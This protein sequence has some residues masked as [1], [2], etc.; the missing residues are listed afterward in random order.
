MRRAPAWMAAIGVL[1]GGWTAPSAASAASV[2]VTLAAG[3]PGN[4]TPTS[5]SEFFFDS[6]HAPPEVAVNQLTGGISATATTGGGF[7]AFGNVGTPVLLN[8]ADGS[9]YIAGGSPPASASSAGAA[10]GTPATAAPVAGGAVPS[11]AALLGIN[12][13]EPSNGSRSLTAT[14]TDSSGTSLGSGTVAVPMGGWWVLGLSPDAVPPTPVTIPAPPPNTG[15]APD[16]GPIS[17]PG[18]ISDPGPV[19]GGGSNSPPTSPGGG[20]VT[21]PEPTPLALAVMG[22]VAARAWRRRAG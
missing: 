16:P 18:P 2:W 20:S 3:L 12:A 6:P 4:E 22:G 13:V 19:N 10:G 21:T 1:V 9:A 14:V 7:S 15:P 11:G 8:L 17:G 5:S